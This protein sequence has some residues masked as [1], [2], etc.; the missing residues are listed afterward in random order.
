MPSTSRMVL[1][2]LAGSLWT[3]NSTSRPTIIR[4]SSSRVVSLISTVPMYLP[5]RRT[6][7]RSATAMISLSLWEMNRMLLPSAARF[8]MI[9]MSSSISWGVS[10]AV[11]SSKI[12][13]SFSRY[14]IFR[15]SVRCCMPTVISS[16]RASGSTRRP[17]F[18]DRASTFSRASAF[19]RKPCL[20]GS[21]PMMMLSRTVKHSTSLKCWWTMPMPRALASLGSLISTTRPSFLMT[22]SSGRYRPNSTLISVDFPAPFSPSRA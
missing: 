19:W 1:P 8:R 18:S 3:T 7:H 2:G 11:G 22:P 14:S 21:T 15:I 9:C 20:Q 16:T 10:T 4:L 6:E 17:Y 13:I 12:R 5:F